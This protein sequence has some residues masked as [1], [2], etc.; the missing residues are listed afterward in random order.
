M[1]TDMDVLGAD[2][3]AGALEVD[4]LPVGPLQSMLRCRRNRRVDEGIGTVHKDAVGF[5][6]QMPK[7]L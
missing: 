2:D 1:F 7:L 4:S 3:A 5:T 6:R